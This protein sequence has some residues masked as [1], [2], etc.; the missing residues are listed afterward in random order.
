MFDYNI[1][2]KDRS[3]STSIISRGGGVLIA[4]RKTISITVLLASNSVEHLFVKIEV[5]SNKIIIATAYFPPRSEPEKY[6]EF[7]ENVEKLS[8]ENPD[9]KLCI[10]GDFNFPYCN[11][12]KDGMSS[13]GTPLT[14]ASPSEVESIQILSA[15]C[16]YHNLYQVN[17]V[18]NAHNNLLDLIFMD[19][20]EAKISTAE[21]VLL[22]LDIYHPPISFEFKCESCV[23]NP[24]LTGD[25]FYRDF[26]AMNVLD[27]TSFLSQFNWDNLFKNKSLD[28]MISIFYDII[29]LTIDLYV[30]KSLDDII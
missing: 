8:D 26:H 30:P 1:H 18:K 21:I 7:T 16:S 5:G 9:H 28:D 19:D 29:Y 12:S 11:W 27:V 22:P 23:N 13:V 15:S 25:A 17:S 4:V 2:R 10:L 3:L 6:W 14:G 20:G 24:G